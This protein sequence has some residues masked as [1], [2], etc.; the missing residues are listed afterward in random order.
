[1]HLV[2]KQHDV[3]VS[4]LSYRTSALGFDS[5]LGSEC[6][7]Q[8]AGTGKEMHEAISFCQLQAAALHYAVRCMD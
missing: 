2:Y 7:I 3:V 8:Y 5:R 4:M 6:V 1:M